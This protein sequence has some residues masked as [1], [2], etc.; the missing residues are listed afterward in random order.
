MRP[1]LLS[2]WA[3][4]AHGWGAEREGPHSSSC[5]ITSECAA[6]SSRW[7]SNVCCAALRASWCRTSWSCSRQMGTVLRMEALGCGDWELLDPSDGMP[8]SAQPRQLIRIRVSCP[9]S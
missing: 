1:C 6:P 5:T 8:Q 4:A 9:G 2:W 3:T 7:L